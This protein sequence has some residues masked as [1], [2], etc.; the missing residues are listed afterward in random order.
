VRRAQA[1]WP[2]LS[3]LWLA[4]ACSTGGPKALEPS[5]VVVTLLGPQTAGQLVPDGGSPI[6]GGWD[7]GAVLPPLAIASPLRYALV[8][9]T[10]AQGDGGSGRLLAT[11]DGPLLSIDDVFTLRLVMPP[12]DVVRELGPRTSVTF[13]SLS[14]TTSVAAYLPKLVIYEDVDQDGSFTSSG[15]DGP[16]QDRV[17]GIA[18]ESAIIAAVLDPEAA[19]KAMPEDSVGDYYAATG[20]QFTPFVQVTDQSIAANWQ[21]TVFLTPDGWSYG[22]LPVEC[23]SIEAGAWVTVRSYLVDAAAGGVLCAA[24]TS[25]TEV[26]TCR[27]VALQDIDA[28]VLTPQQTPELRRTAR[29]LASGDVQ[30]LTVTESM[31][32]PTGAGA[33]P[34]Y[35]GLNV[36]PAVIDNNETTYIASSSALP[37]WWPCGVLVPLQ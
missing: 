29:C 22:S 36:C 14:Q 20:G 16:G 10:Q 24:L 32:E 37:T 26:D 34:Y 25:S 13:S 8:W 18:S 1:R 9:A 30:L 28:P 3:A 12:P 15:L 6:D 31:P 23:R 21:S 4:S 35:P 11:D 7:G 19:L 17:L 27:V 5:S 2:W 33:S